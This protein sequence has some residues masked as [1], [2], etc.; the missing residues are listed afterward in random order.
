MSSSKK[1]TVRVVWERLLS[2]VP[3]N[4]HSQ[5]DFLKHRL[6]SIRMTLTL[7]ILHQ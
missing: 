5:L 4:I 2:K 7:E 3:V 6:K 1:S